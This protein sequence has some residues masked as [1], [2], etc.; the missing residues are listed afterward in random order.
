MPFNWNEF[1]NLATRLDQE[2][3]VSNLTPAE[4][5][6]ARTCVNRAYYAVHWYCRRFLKDKHNLEIHNPDCHQKTIDGVRRH[7]TAEVLSEL[8][9]MKTRRN[10]ADYQDEDYFSKRDITTALD[11]YKKIKAEIDSLSAK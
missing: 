11:R 10:Q 5:A 2:I 4:S 9:N 7:F 1:Y 6:I 8:I 3:P